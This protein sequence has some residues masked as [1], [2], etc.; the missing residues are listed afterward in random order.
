MNV[1]MGQLMLPDIEKQLV[2]DVATEA[3]KLG[4]EYLK[5]KDRDVDT[6]ISEGVAKVTDKE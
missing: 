4:I 6:F 5:L 2:Q 1:Y 3:R